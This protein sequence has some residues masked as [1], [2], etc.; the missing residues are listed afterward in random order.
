M[1]VSGVVWIVCIELVVT[2]YPH[3]NGQT[4]VHIQISP[5]LET[6]WCLYILVC[7]D[8]LIERTTHI[9][10]NTI[11]KTFRWYLPQCN[12]IH[13]KF[14]KKIIFVPT[15]TR[16]KVWYRSRRW[17]EIA[18]TVLQHNRRTI[19]LENGINDIEVAL[20]HVDLDVR[21]WLKR[22]RF[23]FIFNSSKSKIKSMY[24][25]RAIEIAEGVR[26]KNKSDREGLKWIFDE[27]HNRVSSFVFMVTI[28][29]TSSCATKWKINVLNQN[30]KSFWWPKKSFNLELIMFLASVVQNKYEF[31]GKSSIWDLLRKWL[32]C[33]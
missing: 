18:F 10:T 2:D 17:S 33:Q 9:F 12:M 14:K 28:G 19:K 4:A 21:R 23:F 29:T 24:R 3:R 7:S 32:A 1:R 11:D 22:N 26:W 27:R 6:I 8:S 16:A 13:E 5:P 15:F 31:S 25:R 30:G 20:Y